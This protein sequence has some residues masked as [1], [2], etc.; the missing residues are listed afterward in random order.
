[1]RRMVTMA[2]AYTI[3]EADLKGG[4]RWIDSDRFDVI[5]KAPGAPER[6]VFAMLQ[7]LLSERFKLKTHIEDEPRLVYVLSAAATGVNLKPAEAGETS[8]CIPSAGG[9]EK[10]HLS[11]TNI[12]ME[13]LARRLPFVTNLDLPMVDATDLKGGYDFALDWTWGTPLDSGQP[14]RPTAEGLV[15]SFKRLGLLFEGRKY[16]VPVLVLESV[17]RVPIE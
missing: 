17:E 14:N 11:C 9:P 3:R 16:S 4:P 5:A 15:N 8:S 7:T 13:A 1:M 2:Y 10:T 6:M 12:T